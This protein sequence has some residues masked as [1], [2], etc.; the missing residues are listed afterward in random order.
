MWRHNPLTRRL[1]ELLPEIGELRAVRATFGFRL[2]REVDVRLVPELGGGALLDVGC[3]CVSAARLL[4]GREPDRV[5]GEAV[6]GPSGVDVRFTGVLRFGDVTAEF[7]R[8][9][10][11]APRPRGDRERGNDPRAGALALERGRAA[12][13]RRGGADR[14][15][16]LLPASSWRT[17]PPPCEATRSRCSA[18]PSRSARARALDALLARPSRAARSSSGA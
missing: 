2:T 8:V 16:Q 12:A 17:S 9:H 1:V 5:Y 10:G 15:G 4:A 14:A 6:R 11:R 3:Y 18:A 13:E 7:T